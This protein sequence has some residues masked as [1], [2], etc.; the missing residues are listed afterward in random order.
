MPELRWL[1]AGPIDVALDGPDL[2]YVRLG[3][4]ELVRRVYV[5]VRDLNWDTIGDVEREVSVD[6]TRD[7]F[8]IRSQ[9][10]HRRGPIDFRW[11]GVIEGRD[12]GTIS[13]ALDGWCESEFDYARIGLCVHH[14]PRECAGR[15]YVARTPE[16]SATGTLP[17]LIEP[18]LSDVTNGYDLPLFD[19][20]SELSIALRDGTSLEFSFEGDLFEMEDQR[21]WTDASFKTF[22]TPSY[23]GYQHTATPGQRITQRVVMRFR[24]APGTSRATVPRRTPA[25]RAVLTLGERLGHG[26][27]PIG[28]G[29]PG[30]G[31]RH[32][33]RERERV[34]ALRPAHLR[35]DIKRGDFGPLREAL[36]LCADVGA[37]LE[38]AVHVDAGRVGAMQSLA[39]PLALAGGIARVLVFQ[40]D[41]ATTPRETIEAARQ[42]LP[43]GVPLVGGTDANFCDIN[44]DRPDV[45]GL[46]GIAYSINS[47]VHAFD[48]LSLVEALAGHGDTVV[49]ARELFPGLPII[50]SPVSLRP[51]FNLDPRQMT[52]FGA[53]W[54]LGS[55]KALSESGASSLTYYE[56]AGA[57]GLFER[58]TGD[59]SPGMLFPVYELFTALT[60]LRGA[61]LVS[62]VP[63]DPLAVTGLAFRKGEAV[64][65]VIGNLTNEPL[66][67]SV[68][69][70]GVRVRLAGYEF[71]SVVAP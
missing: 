54:T 51:R 56:T 30:D 18:Q 4:T 27:P 15:P 40:T 11:E 67:V 43:P 17:L 52:A 22:S 44:R 69:P 20:F 9:L 45:A 10:R 29:L 23:L 1:R 16:R 31:V 50:V 49:S 71:R 62:F 59:L 58:D 64:Q 53:V 68:A 35:V 61:E 24:P 47:Q 13:Y 55:V 36:A 8:S 63:T 66:T 33:D 39:Q 42:N 57:R 12:D 41:A 38:L 25:E 3:E 60:E 21:N 6:D 70:I 7:A 32:T 65:M 26:L 2:R 5:A 34:K 28:F 48:E 19:P 46:D 37:E 14:P